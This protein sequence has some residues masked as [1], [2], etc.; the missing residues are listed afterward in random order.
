MAGSCGAFRR[1]LRAHRVA[2]RRFAIGTGIALALAAAGAASKPQV[3]PGDC[4]VFYA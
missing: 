3:A 1:F 2:L 4:R